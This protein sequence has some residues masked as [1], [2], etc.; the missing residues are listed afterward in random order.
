MHGISGDFPWKVGENFH[1][2][3]VIGTTDVSLVPRLS[4]AGATPEL[5]HYTP[6]ADAE[7]LVTGRTSVLKS[8]PVTPD[9]IPS[10]AVLTRAL[11]RMQGIRPLVVDAGSRVQPISIPYVT[12]GGE[13]G[14]DIRKGSMDRKKVEEVIERG[15]IL[16]GS[17]DGEFLVIGES[18]PGGTTTAM[19]LLNALGYKTA[20]KVSSAS[21]NNPLSLKE[22]IVRASMRKFSD[23]IDVVSSVGDPVQVGVSSIVSGFPGKVILA[24]GT[25]MI[26]MASLIKEMCPAKMKDIVVATT[27]WVAT[28]RSADVQGLAGEVGVRLVYSSIDLSRSIHPGLHYYERGYVKEGVGLGGALTLSYLKGFNE[29]EILRSIDEEYD[30][31]RVH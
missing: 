13:P 11:L 1:F 2:L 18:I 23:Y 28:D 8:L 16:G 14:K 7:Y 27:R 25:Q 12:L 30:K 21:P 10:P 22:E 31:L 6:A 19:A 26:A 20:G 17:M 3:L 4:I 15:K 9:G 29:G 24:G 5:T